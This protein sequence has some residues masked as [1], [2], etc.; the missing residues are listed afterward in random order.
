MAGVALVGDD[1]AKATQEDSVGLSTAQ[2]QSAR[3][4]AGYNEVAERKRSLFWSFVLRLSGPIPWLLEACA[5]ITGALHSYENMGL[6]IALLLINAVIGIFQQHG[7][8][9]AVSALKM[10]V[11]TRVRTLRDHAWTSVPSRELVPGD[12]VRL[13]AGD[14]VGAD[15]LLLDGSL[16]VDISA[17]TGESGTVL[18]SPGS[19]ALAGGLCRHGEAL[20]RVTFTGSATSFGKTVVLIGSSHPPSRSSSVL[21][22]ATVALFSVGAVCAALLL[23]T[24]AIRGT[25]LLDVLPLVILVL[26]SCIPSAL[27]AFFTVATAHGAH[28]LATQG[29]LV[30]SLAALENAA[31]MAIM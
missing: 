31:S 19:T 2:V 1:V 3:M 28:A 14:A 30:A 18:V 26:V 9:V 7:A 13:R 15:V 10:Q 23:V 27:P 24:A 11:A 22:H 17:I 29:V 12:V 20:C 5:V 16:E 21:G 8:E 6:I 4:I 25:P